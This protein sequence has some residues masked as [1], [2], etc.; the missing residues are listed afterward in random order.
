MIPD[1]HFGT[2]AT[3]NPAPWRGVESF[4]QD[5]DLELAETPPDVI[6]MLG[7]DPLDVEEELVAQDSIALDKK[8][9]RQYD[10]DGRLHLEKSNISKANVC[11][12]LGSEINAPD[13]ITLDPKKTYYLLRDPEELK[14]AAA[15]FNNIPILDEHIPVHST[16]PQ[17]QIVIGSTGTDADFKAPYLTN[18]LVFWDQDAIDDI[19]S[20]ER[21][22][23]SCAYHY[24]ADMTP[25]VY[26]GTKYDGVMREIRG[27]HVALVPE[28][29]AGSDVVVGDSTDELK[30]ALLEALLSE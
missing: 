7:F 20:E 2:A 21:V 16:S 6:A 14:K 26:N 19:E 11:P 28:G 22:E 1:V 5:D 23:L 18:S 3:Q 12:Y 30:W 9:L 29:R 15:T 10:Q 8:S 24:V 27:N 25:G 17:K 13:G 4:E